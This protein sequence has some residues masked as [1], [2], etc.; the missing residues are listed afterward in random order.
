MA[1]QGPSGAMVFV[2]TKARVSLIE[3]LTLVLLSPETISYC[4][5]SEF[6]PLYLW[7]LTQSE[8]NA[9][10]LQAEFV[11]HWDSILFSSL[12]SNATFLFFLF[13]IEFLKF[14]PKYGVKF[15][16]WKKWVFFQMFSIYT[17][18]W[19]LIHQGILKIS[20]YTWNIELYMSL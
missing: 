8:Y 4:T 14:F 19:I 17:H 7:N 6:R 16:V 10:L 11:I 13:W 12:L 5:L 20:N 18:T 1:L 2:Q 9:T 3:S 15:W